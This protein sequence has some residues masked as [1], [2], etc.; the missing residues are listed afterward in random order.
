[1]VASDFLCLYGDNFHRDL[2]DAVAS[3]FFLDTAPNLIRYLSVIYSCLKPGGVLINVG[4][5]LWHFEGHAPGTHG[6]SGQTNGDDGDMPHEN[7]YDHSTSGI[8]D[9]GNFELTDDEVMALVEK[10]GFVVEQRNTGFEA[11][12][13][14]D[15][16]SMLKMVYKACSWVARKPAQKD[17]D[18]E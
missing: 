4:P 18:I 10:L 5:L 11:P 14:Q 17:D 7:A 6:Y 1:M 3:I 15:P 13:I 9:P 8:A 16:E 2:Y 12:Y